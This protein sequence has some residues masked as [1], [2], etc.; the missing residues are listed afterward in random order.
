MGDRIS[1]KDAMF[2]SYAKY[3]DYGVNPCSPCATGWLPGDCLNSSC[4]AKT[5]WKGASSVPIMVPPYVPPRN[6]SANSVRS[7]KELYALED[8]LRVNPK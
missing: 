6:A 1:S 7:S 3:V 5:N 2:Q 8:R 4:T